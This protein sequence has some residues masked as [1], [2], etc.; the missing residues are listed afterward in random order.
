M[1]ATRKLTLLGLF[2]LMLVVPWW[3]L[4]A[5]AKPGYALLIG[6]GILPPL[7][8]AISTWKRMRNWS[9]I[10]ALGM[11]PY[12]AAGMMDIVATSGALFASLALGSIAIATF[13][14][15]LDAGKR[16]G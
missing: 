15:V 7:L 3:L 4:S 5:Y 10:T 16:D 8:L 1:A 6:I 14:L 11:I 2:L 12:A 9:G 13:F